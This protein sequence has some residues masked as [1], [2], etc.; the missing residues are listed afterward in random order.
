MLHRYRT[1]AFSGSLACA[2]QLASTML[3]TWSWQ[4][5]FCGCGL[6]TAAC[7]HQQSGNSSTDLN[8]QSQGVSLHVCCVAA[9]YKLLDELWSEAEDLMD[10]GVT[11]TGQ[12]FDAA[13]V[14]RLG[15]YS[16]IPTHNPPQHKIA[17]AVRKVRMSKVTTQQMLAVAIVADSEGS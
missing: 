11:G 13:S 5:W 9:F 12:G 15:S 16:Y 10:R 3:R 8:C 2:V 7:K 17:D 14:G 6:A 4:G 1:S